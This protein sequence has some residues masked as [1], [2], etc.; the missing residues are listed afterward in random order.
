MFESGIGQWLVL[1]SANRA[2]PA[3]LIGDNCEVRGVRY[4]KQSYECGETE[5]ANPTGNTAMLSHSLE[6][7]RTTQITFNLTLFNQQSVYLL[8]CTSGTQINILETAVILKP[9]W[10][11]KKILTQKSFGLKLVPTTN[12]H[13]KTKVVFGSASRGFSH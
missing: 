1:T 7:H 8:V 10:K 2:A 9:R 13:D 11:W 4:S 5:G 6:H 12:D 3:K